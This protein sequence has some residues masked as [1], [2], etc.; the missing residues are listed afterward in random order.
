MWRTSAL[1][2]A[3]SVHTWLVC[4]Q[5]PSEGSASIDDIPV[6]KEQLRKIHQLMDKDGDGKVSATDALQFSEETQIL[7]ARRTFVTVDRN[8]DGKA[9][10]KEVL[11]AFLNY[12]AD[13]MDELKA[14]ETKK[15]HAADIDGNGVLNRNELATLVRPQLSRRVLDVIVQNNMKDWDENGDGRVSWREFNPGAEYVGEESIARDKRLWAILDRDS[16]GHLDM[17]EYAAFETN[18]AQTQVQME[19]LVE[20]G[21]ADGDGH[22]TAQELEDIW[23]WVLRANVLYHVQTW[24]EHHEL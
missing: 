10:V 22:L 24:A 7:A 9:T 12:D 17:E 5:A 18:A 4:G 1:L 21:D 13:N 19:L 3:W 15:F 2:A 20:K 23:E 16:N 11:A 8:K 14:F 6:T